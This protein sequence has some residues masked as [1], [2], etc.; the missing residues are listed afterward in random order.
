MNSKEKRALSKCMAICS[1]AEKCVSEIQKKLDVWEIESSGAQEIIDQLIKEKFIDE[2]RFARYYTRDKY[3]F[4]HWGK[5]KIAFQLK[6]KA[7]PKSTIDEALGEIDE[8]EYQNILTKLLQDKARKTKF[9]SE[10][11]RNG[12]L[13]R[14]AQGRGFEYELIS[15]LLKEV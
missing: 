2:S 5:I 13:V 7:I 8:E 3:R 11:E 9:E 14:F 6:M 12:K 15:K 10:Y 4:N 1:K